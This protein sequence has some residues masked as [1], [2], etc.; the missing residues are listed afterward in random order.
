MDCLLGWPMREMASMRHT[1]PFSIS[2]KRYVLDP[3]TALMLPAWFGP[4]VC[5]SSKCRPVTV[6]S[7]VCGAPGTRPFGAVF[8]LTLGTSITV[9]A[10]PGCHRW[11]NQVV[12]YFRATAKLLSKLALAARNPLT[13]SVGSQPRP[14]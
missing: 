5:N 2:E 6:T 3:R 14:G 13:I 7:L 4:A 9:A 10:R 1:P 11:L 8:E 12:R